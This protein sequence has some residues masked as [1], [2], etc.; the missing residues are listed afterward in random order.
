MCNFLE[1]GG[2]RPCWGLGESQGRL[3]EEGLPRRKVK[4]EE[5]HSRGNSI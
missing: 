3:P 4:D 1:P 5:E 2:V